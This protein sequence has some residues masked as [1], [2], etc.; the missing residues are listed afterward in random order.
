MPRTWTQL[1][2][3]PPSSDRQQLFWRTY[4]CGASCTVAPRLTVAFSQLSGEHARDKDEDEAVAGEDDQLRH[5]W[6]SDLVGQGEGLAR[7]Y[8]VLDNWN[9]LKSCTQ[10]FHSC[11]CRRKRCSRFPGSTRPD[12]AGRLIKMP[13]CSS[14]GPFTQVSNSWPALQTLQEKQTEGFNSWKMYLQENMWRAER[15][16]RRHGK[17]TSAV[18]W[19]RSLTSRRWKRWA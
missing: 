2:T 3:P 14:C 7:C 17:P 1:P 19:T 16:T 13:A 6:G 18:Q 5:H 8:S 4:R 12:T 11:F 9:P 10:Y 15:V